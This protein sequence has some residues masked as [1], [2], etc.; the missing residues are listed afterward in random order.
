MRNKIN[1][2]GEDFILHVTKY[3]NNGRLAIF[4]Y[5]EHYEPYAD[6]TINLPELPI[7]EINEGFISGDLQDCVPELLKG[8]KDKGFIKESFG[9]LPYNYGN[10]EYVKFD[11]DKLKEFDSIGVFEVINSVDRNINIGI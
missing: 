8:L 4:L 11:L 5:N 6:V 9:F 7:S 2:N 1:I 3:S 10:Y